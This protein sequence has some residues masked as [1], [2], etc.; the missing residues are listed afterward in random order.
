MAY[1]GRE[2]DMKKILL[3]LVL[4]AV[5]AAL[6]ACASMEK[7]SRQRQASSLLAYLYPGKEQI[8]PA[9]ETI[10]EIRPPLRIGV[11]FVP[12]NDN[13]IMRLPESDRLTLAA[14]VKE[15]F[16]GNDLFREVVPVASAYLERAAASPI[17]IA[18]RPC[19]ASTRWP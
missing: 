14:R 17:S 2:G 5:A 7:D 8:P 1:L 15:A 9:A 16:A 19:C 11:A 13:P 12:D 3:F 4:A 6:G 10:A 18:S